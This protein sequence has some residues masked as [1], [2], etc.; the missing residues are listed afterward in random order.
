MEGVTVHD[1]LNQVSIESF[2]EQLDRSKDQASL[3]QDQWKKGL[4]KPV[5]MWQEN[6]TDKSLNLLESI[7]SSRAYNLAS[8]PHK[9][10]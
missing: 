5:R 9:P 8:P 1:S 2:E 10:Q 7:K 6:S 4:K 3:T